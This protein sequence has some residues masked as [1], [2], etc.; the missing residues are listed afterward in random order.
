MLDRVSLKEHIPSRN[1]LTKYNILSVNQLGAK[2]KMIEAWKLQ[3]VDDYPFQLEPTYIDR[4]SL[5][6]ESKTYDTHC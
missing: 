5:I 4:I 2:M 3:N 6:F 1:L